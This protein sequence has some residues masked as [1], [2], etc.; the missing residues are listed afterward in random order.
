MKSDDDFIVLK[1]KEAKE[2]YISL[3]LKSYEPILKKNARSLKIVNNKD[4]DKYLKCQLDIYRD[5]LEGSMYSINLKNLKNSLETLLK[6]SGDYRDV[7]IKN[8]I[9]RNV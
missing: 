8:S 7:M 9:R 2:L 4:I 5:K 6:E 1:Y 3:K